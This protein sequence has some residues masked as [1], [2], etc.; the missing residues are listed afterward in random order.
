[1]ANYG[2]AYVRVSSKKQDVSRQKKEL[3]KYALSKK[4]K[5]DKYFEDIISASK[6]RMNERKGLNKLKAYIS[7]DKND[8]KN[9]FVHEVS[10]LGRKNFEVQNIIEEFYQQGVNIHFM[11]LN[12]ST[13]DK[14]GVKS[15]ESSI[16]LS[17]LG[18]MA[19]NENRL[20]TDRI[21]SGLL[22]SAR[23]GL[24]F[25]NKITGYNKGLDGRP[26]I[27]NKVA[28]MV[29]RMYEL[30]SEKNTLYFIAK[31]INSEYNVNINSKTISGIIKN[32]F[33]VGK[34]KYLGETIKVDKIVDAKVWKS[35]ND[36]LS[37]RKS[38]TKRYN[39]NEN[40]VEGKIQC[41]KCESPMYQIVNIKG[42]S[43]MFK[44]SDSC[45]T[46][47]NRPWLYEMIRYVIDKHTEK[48]N[49][50]EFKLDLK[51]KIAENKQFSS[52][53]KAEMKVT[54]LAQLFNYERFTKGKVKEKIYQKTDSKYEKKLD[55][56]E[57]KLNDSL[58]KNNSYQFALKSRPEYFS[59]DLKVYK[60]QIQDILKEVEVNDK[61]ITININNII[62]YTIPQ[63]NGTKLGWIVR[64]SKGGKMVFESPFKSE[65]KIR[66]YIS[67]DELSIMEDDH[68]RSHEAT[69]AFEKEI[70]ESLKNRED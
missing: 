30:A 24:A 62:K 43:N 51:N 17:I 15:P 64:K 46:S 48:I 67:D 45:K 60:V 35:A 22:G 12:L 5:I 16:M 59:F 40:I 21:K 13:L 41:Y 14:D 47:V 28:P 1:M 29:R 54:E 38:F 31:K 65:I 36:F 6:S 61:L 8:I 66:N 69:I 63:I 26:V 52:D 19:E 18:S 11:D 10:R 4:F 37:S 49:N 27:D 56:I 55:S 25:N 7:D 50:K 57:V 58:V 70:E 44:C 42:R 32:S 33:Y 68:N 53:L 34:R 20:L 39:V 23:K 9:I 3:K 2:V